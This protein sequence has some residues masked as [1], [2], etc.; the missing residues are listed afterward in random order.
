MTSF[1]QNVSPLVSL[2][3]VAAANVFLDGFILDK[4]ESD[5]IYLDDIVF[6][7]ITTPDKQEELWLNQYYG[8]VLSFHSVHDDRSRSPLI[9]T[10]NYQ[11]TSQGV[12]YRTEVAACLKYMKEEDWRNHVLEGSSEGVDEKQSEAI[13]KGWLGTYRAEADAAISTLRAAMESDAGVKV[14]REKAEM[15]LRRWTQ[16]KKICE[17]AA[18]AV[19]L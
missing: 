12:C 11:V 17:S 2:T 1:W 7:D 15:L 4:N 6:R 5:C 14:H 10:S 16:I 8:Y 19:D 3:N 18:A 9:Y 13:I